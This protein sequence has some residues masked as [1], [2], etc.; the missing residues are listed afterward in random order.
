MNQETSMSTRLNLLALLAASLIAAPFQLTAATPPTTADQHAAHHPAAGAAALNAAREEQ[1]KAMREMRDK[2]MNAK[3]PEERQALMADHM[4]AM[5][6][7]MQMMQGMS[8]MASMGGKA[9][10]GRAPAD[11]AKRQQMMEER[12][13]MMQTMMEMMMQR[14]PNPPVAK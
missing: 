4:K 9:S 3:T 13:E 10:G 6:G 5:Q 11:M 1:M 14:L 12:M 7:G 2:M 8:G